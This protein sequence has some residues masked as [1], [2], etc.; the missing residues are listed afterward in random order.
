M[1]TMK[2]L[3]VCLLAVM[4]LA[5]TLLLPA[6]AAG[7][8]IKINSDHDT[9]KYTAYQIFTGTLDGS[10]LSNLVWGNGVT[11][12]G[13][14]ALQTL[15]SKSDASGIAGTLSDTTVAA[16]AENVAQYLNE[17]NG[18]EGEY[19]S[20]TKQFVI[21]DLEAGYYL[22]V[23]TTADSEMNGSEHAYSKHMLRIVNNV[24]L[25][26]KA[27]VPTLSKEVK[28]GAAGTY[29]EAVSA[30]VGDTVYFRLTASLHTYVHDYEKCYFRFE[31]VLPAG[32]TF[33]S[34][35]VSVLSG[36]TSYAMDPGSYSVD[37]AGAVNVTIQ[38]IHA[39][40]RAATNSPTVISD[41]I[42]VEIETK[43]NSNLVLGSGGNENKAKLYFSNNP[44]E[45]YTGTGTPGSVGV[46]NE[47]KA[48]V[49]SYQVN[50]TKVDA[51]DSAT[52]LR[53]AQFI[54]G[55]KN[56]DSTYTWFTA[57][58]NGVVNGTTASEDSATR[59]TTNENGLLSVKGL[60]SGTYHIREKVAP[61]Q[62]NLLTSDIIVQYSG[63]LSQDTGTLNA[64]TITSVSGVSSSSTDVDTGAINL[65]VTNTKG[66]VLP[67]TGGIG[68]TIFYV[69]GIVLMLGAAAVIIAKK[70]E[71]K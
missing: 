15:Y 39:A 50:L 31:D 2:K 26:P 32:L 40:I 36:T 54:L 68:T 24:E 11:V 18:E 22:I 45:D 8:T 69:A 37:T 57:D 30:T 60:A 66:A 67:E 1:K 71:T 34:A 42:V 19:K 65:T 38:D 14:A 46:T 20:A 33:E 48:I 58:A 51:A 4:M 23:E 56:G 53:G 61:A 21:S 41:K 35:T 27:G 62:Y 16:F 7:Y 55:Y 12:E 28:L 10:V 3:F 70:R 64:L 17:S 59:F 13:Q 44:N 43:V 5:A 25:S 49:Y 47:A 63:S 52:K 9:H 29:K 6:S